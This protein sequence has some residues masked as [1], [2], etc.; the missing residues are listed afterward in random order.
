MLAKII[1]FF[2]GIYTLLCSIFSI[3]IKPAEPA[4][5]TKITVDGPCIM[6]ELVENPSTGFG[7][8][9]SIEDE[10]VFACT[11][12]TYDQTQTPG[13]AG[14]PGT[15]RYTF[16]ALAPGSTTI[17]LT[18]RRPWE[19]GETAEVITLLASADENLTVSCTR[20]SD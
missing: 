5:T 3:P 1:A 11:A 12:D 7:W 19:G 8:E 15:R 4:E 16:S 20:Q 10:T 14:A 9:Y 13:M 18:Y 6:L 17:V 2:M